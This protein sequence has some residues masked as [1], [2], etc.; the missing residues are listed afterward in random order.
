MSLPVM[1][2]EER[3]RALA[4][5]IEV[6]RERSAARTSLKSGAITLTDF[7]VTDNEVLKRTKVRQVIL[8]LPGVGQVRADRLMEQAK[9]DPRR[10]VGGLGPVQRATLA[11]L[12]S[13]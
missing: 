11:D 9:V 13:A 8:A 4:K 12:L 3:E 6:R 5:S 7:L 10:R 2:A 1:T